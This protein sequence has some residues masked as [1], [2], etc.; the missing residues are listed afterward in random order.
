MQGSIVTRFVLLLA[1]LLAVNF[2]PAFGQQASA[3][4][5]DI[6]LLLDNSGSMKKNDPRFVT[7]E[8][9]RQFVSRTPHSGRLALLLFDQEAR[10]IVPLTVMSDPQRELAISGLDRINYRGLY[11]NIPA[12]F[13][14]ALYELKT[15]GREGALKSIILLTDGI[16]D[17]GDKGRDLERARWLREELAADAARLGITVFGIGLGAKSDIQL[18]QSLAQRTQGDY[19]RAYRPEDLSG[20]LVRIEK[21]MAQSL[22][23]RIALNQTKAE[24]VTVAG[25]KVTEPSKELSKEAQIPDVK[26]IDPSP[27]STHTTPIPPPV[28]KRPQS[29]KPQPAGEAW[30]P[31][32]DLRTLGLGA[33]GLLL[34]ALAFSLLTRSR[35]Y[36]S[37][38]KDTAIGPLSVERIPT[39]YLYDINGITDFERYELKGRVIQ[40]GRIPPDQREM[41]EHIVIPLP[42]VGRRHAVLEYKH[43]TFWLVDQKSVNGTFVN[44]QRVFDEVCLKHGD[45]IRFHEAEFEFVQEGMDR[46]DQTLLVTRVKGALA[47]PDTKYD[48]EPMVSKWV[49]DLVPDNANKRPA[50]RAQ[51][52]D[53]SA[54]EFLD[55]KIGHEF[56]EDLASKVR[57]A[58]GQS[59]AEIPTR[60]ETL[61]GETEPPDPTEHMHADKIRT[62]MENAGEDRK[63]CPSAFATTK[64]SPLS[65]LP[66]EETTTR[67]I[68]RKVTDE[69]GFE[70]TLPSKRIAKN[71]WKDFFGE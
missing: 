56:A 55:Q 1:G 70:E 13:E 54:A 16:V 28:P 22:A 4:T 7:K 65:G 8:A 17:T 27:K 35:R 43:H 42:T 21:A 66:D 2:H 10:L 20:I 69:R 18:L 23:L 44:G 9:A 63:S 51:V 26:P 60:E 59:V 11:T 46:A 6:V 64:D 40:I 39:T 52:S 19:F 37:S 33:A 49:N 36:A 34:V 24:K 62:A 30:P 58:T 57:L 67:K 71:S 53:E 32:L 15:N 38:E 25:E 61:A 47:G 68:K 31:Y 41:V 50:D 12:A 3:F 48:H 14:Q 5:Q 45:R 29:V